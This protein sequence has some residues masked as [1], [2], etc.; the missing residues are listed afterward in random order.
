[1]AAV[2]DAMQALYEGDRAR[3]EGLLP[4]DIE[5]DAF[6]AAAFG[7]I[8]RL[9]ELLDADPGLARAW[10]RDG[11]TALHLAAFTDEADAARLLIE[12]G[13]DVEAVS[14]HAFIRARPLNTAAFARA[15]AVARVLLESGA[16]PNGTGEAGYTAL[17]AAAQNDDAE[18]ARLLLDH[19]AD[20]NAQTQDGRAPR[21]FAEGE[22]AALLAG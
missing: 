16:D 5:L 8:A 2:T 17:H 12:R 18:L 22:L 15:H 6:H 4:V 9:R 19:G 3:A 11:F 10:S 13:A 21:D 7:R 14:R 20:P 1:M